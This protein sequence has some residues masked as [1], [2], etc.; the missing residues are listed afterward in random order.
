MKQLLNFSL[1][2]WLPARRTTTWLLWLLGLLLAQ[3]AAVLGQSTAPFVVRAT[4]AGPLSLAAGQQVVL[5]AQAVYPA[6]VQTGTGFNG[7]VNA[8]AVQ[9]DGKILVGGDFTSYNGTTCNRIARLNPDGSL[10]TGFTTGTGL[11]GGVSAIAV[12]TSTGNILV[13]GSFTAYGTTSCLRLARLLPTGALDPTFVTSSVNGGFNG[14][15]RAIGI[16]STGNVVVGGEFT[17]YG[18]NT[19]SQYL[20]RLSSTGVLDTG[21]ALTTHTSLNLFNG[22]V[23]ALVVQSGDN[24]V[25]GGEFVVAFTGGRRGIAR[26]GVNGVLDASFASS[27]GA[28]PVGGGIAA[29]AEFGGKLLVGGNFLG[30]VSNGITYNYNC[31]AL[32]TSAGELDTGNFLAAGFSAG[33]STGVNAIAVQSATRIVVGGQFSTY[34]GISRNNVVGLT[35]TGTLDA[36]FSVGTGFSTIVSSLAAQPNG[37]IVVGGQFTTYNGTSAKYLTRLTD[38]GGSDA[39]DTPT[40]G[41]SYTWTPGGAATASIT[42]SPAASTTTTYS[43]TATLNGFSATSNVVSITVGAPFITAI[44]V[45]VTPTAPAVCAGAS[46]TLTAMAVYPAFNPGT[47]FNDVVYATAVQP[48]GKVLVGGLFNNYNGI[49]RNCIARLNTDGTLDASFA[50]TGTGLNTNAAYGVLSLALQPDGK[51]LVGGRFTTYNGT[52]RNAIVRLNA[53]GSLDTGF[54]VGSGFDG[55][56]QG[57]AVQPDG[58]VLACGSMHSYNGVSRKYVARLNADGTLDTSFNTTGTGFNNDLAYAVAIQPDGKVLVGGNF[59][60]YN[61]ITRNA[62]ARLNADGSLDTNFAQ[63]S[64]VSDSGVRSLLLQPD[65]RVLAGGIFTSSNS[66]ALSSILRFNTDGS[67]DTS[68]APTG[69]GLNGEVYSQALQPDGKVLAGGIFTNYNGTTR[70]Y[71]AR[72]NADGS[73]DTSFGST[74]TGLNDAVWTI[75]RQPADSKMLV[76]GNFTTYNGTTRNRIARLNTDGSLNNT[77]APAT[78][79]IAYIWTPSGATTPITTV[80]PNVTTSYTAMATVAGASASTSVVVTVSPLPVAVPGSATTV[81]S[82]Q[83]AQLGGTPMTGLN[84]SWS[85][86]TGLSNATVANPTATVVNTTGA[87]IFR[88]YTLTVT[89]FPGNCQA[90]GTVTVIVNPAPTI[91][92]VPPVSGPIGTPVMIYGTGLQGTTAVRFNGIASPTT[93]VYSGPYLTATIPPGTTSGLVQVLVTTPCGMASFNFNFTVVNTLTVVTTTGIQPGTYTKIIITKTGTGTLSG[94]VTVTDSVVV[95]NGGRLRLG[96]YQ[97]QGGGVFLLASGGTLSLGHPGGLNSPTGSAVDMANRIYSDDANY[98]YTGIVSQVTGPGLPARVRNLTDS[99]QR[100]GQLT[101]TAPTS[102]AQVL[103]MASA[104]DFNLNGQGLKLLSSASGTALVVNGPNAGKVMGQATMERYI[105]PTFNAGTGYRYYSP[106]VDGSTVSTLAV[107]TSFV[108]VVNPAYD[109]STTP[110]TVTPFPTVFRYD[111]MRL[112]TLRPGLPAFD[113]GL[114]SPAALTEPLAVGKGYAVNIAATAKVT[115]AG[116]LTTGDQVLTNL[117][118]SAGPA[119][120]TTGWNLVGNPYPAPLNWDSVKVADRPNL[121]AALYTYESTGPN[122]GIYF[123]YVNGVGGSPVVAAGKAFFVRVS[124]GAST[125]SLT[126]RNRHRLTSYATQAPFART[127]LAN[128]EMV[129]LELDYNGGKKGGRPPTSVYADNSAAPY[130]RTASTFNPA[131]DAYRIPATTGL[132]LSISAPTQ[133]EELAIKALPPFAAGQEVPLTVRVPQAGSQLY[134]LH[135]FTIQNLPSGLFAFLD[136]RLLN[137][138]VNLSSQSSYSFTVAQANTAI[139]N[140]FFLRFGPATTTTPTRTWAAASDITVYPNPAHTQATVQIPGVLGA[141][142]VE[143]TLLN[144]LG[145]VVQQ[146]RAALPT[147]GTRLSLSVNSLAAGVYVLRLRAG[148]A[149]AV[150]RLVVE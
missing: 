77:D 120:S 106:P 101:L 123:S 119:A 141:T 68:F 95:R 87:P 129:E 40:S 8:T 144:A 114:L 12:Q 69:T 61:G 39:A 54:T 143:A 71:I 55:Y 109:M 108:P 99:T 78:G 147:T 63:A 64:T 30:Y 125:G 145:Q 11:N 131:L 53:D 80:T 79:S 22:R 10:D 96:Q 104:T 17:A 43:A 32:L 35:A 116:T 65:G 25:V 133:D 139:T 85:P 48:D 83:P 136:D 46:Q 142:E 21:F 16:Q 70:N 146:Q 82:G 149:T 2:G 47:G 122:A 118:R 7:N 115:F 117:T 137:N 34:S 76:G 1:R 62:I 13:G 138:S 73:L 98:I 84:Y 130:H 26:L 58:K 81:C 27:T 20:V 45:R 42:V 29:I 135:A 103:T 111:Q 28:G 140:R 89:S 23:L 67:L 102:V 93:P 112:G 33:T 124:Q 41:A 105:D 132:N 107:G 15:V 126:L 113:N 150:R 36:N 51:V 57:L 14:T 18:T 3:P 86:A 4:P 56:V 90:S 60:S 110:L 31:L 49:T 127:Q 88:V 97:L 66:T 37:K 50:P 91:T 128:P 121:D 5:T 72:L 59:T 148:D 74:G 100:G 52:A 92:S 75:A 6:F 94:N 9:A 134:E 44:A 19:A 24:L 38:A